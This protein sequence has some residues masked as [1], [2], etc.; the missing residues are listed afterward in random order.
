ML[1]ETYSKLALK[2]PST[3]S[4]QPHCLL[5]LVAMLLPIGLTGCAPRQLGKTF[6]NK[7]ATTVD[8]T[9][10]T[11]SKAC[12]PALQHDYTTEALKQFL[13][14][15]L[16][17]RA[18]F[19]TYSALDDNA[20][21]AIVAKPVSDAPTP[22]TSVLNDSQTPVLTRYQAVTGVNPE[23]ITATNTTGAAP[24]DALCA[25]HPGTPVGFR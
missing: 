20:L 15:P 2:L 5:M 3:I 22:D 19:S 12:W 17:F 1:K 11:A 10:V 6:A 23:T 24:P 4:R 13:A 14:D 9:W 25:V 7:Q 18:A 21:R 16:H 8:T